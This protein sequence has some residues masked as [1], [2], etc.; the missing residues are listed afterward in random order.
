MQAAVEKFLE[1]SSDIGAK[2]IS[3]FVILLICFVAIR[4]SRFL[5][6]RFVASRKPRGRIFDERR[7]ATVSSMV[8]SVIKYLI[9]FLAIS[10]ILIQ[11]GVSQNSIIAVAGAA[12]VAI[13]LGAQ[14]FM[15]DLISGFFMV[16]EDQ[17]RV[18]DIVTIADKTGIVEDINLRTTII[19]GFS[20]EVYIIPNG[21][22]DIVT[23][24]CKDFI[25]EIISI[26]VSYYESADNVINILKNEME[27]AAPNI[28]GLRGIPN[29]L[30]IAEMKDQKLKINI[31][32]ECDIKQNYRIGRELKLRIKNR[33]DAE[34]ISA[35]VI[36]NKIELTGENPEV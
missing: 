24:M 10:T 15:G 34:N 33:L 28:E 1:G 12:S 29:V 23:N 18:G 6:N 4:L 30:G 9:Y 19:R 3:S 16:S 2:V 27:K 36:K 35:P 13:G 25:N 22:I 17:F 26:E 8:S 32:A 7:A 11:F 31:I 20:G 14:S 5:I 21:S